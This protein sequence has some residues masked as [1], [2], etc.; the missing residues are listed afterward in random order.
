MPEAT[1]HVMATGIRRHSGAINEAD[2]QFEDAVNNM[3]SHTDFD[4]GEDMYE[5]MVRNDDR[6]VYVRTINQVREDGS[7][8]R[9]RRVYIQRK[10]T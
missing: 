2:K 6:E 1:T 5:D 7:L 8:I 10:E 4:G 3:Y 9:Y